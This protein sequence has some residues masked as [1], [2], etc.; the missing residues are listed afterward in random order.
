MTKDA[1]MYRKSFRI[2]LKNYQN[3]GTFKGSQTL[4]KLFFPLLFFNI[5]G[6]IEKTNME[7]KH[8]HLEGNLGLILGHF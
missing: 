3:F 4:K 5:F 7:L 2:L 1:K 8:I 6:N